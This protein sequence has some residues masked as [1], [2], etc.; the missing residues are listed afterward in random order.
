MAMVPTAL[1]SSSAPRDKIWLSR[2]GRAS[3]H[4]RHAK[5]RQI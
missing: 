5:Q 3:E 1:L 2:K 4:H